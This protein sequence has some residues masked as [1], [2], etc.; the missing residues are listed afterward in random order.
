MADAWPAAKAVASVF[1]DASSLHRWLNFLVYA[2]F[3]PW[4]G[5]FLVL[6]QVFK[7]FRFHQILPPRVT[8]PELASDDI[9]K[10]MRIVANTY[11]VLGMND[12]NT[13]PSTHID[14]CSPVKE[15]NVADV[16]TLGQKTDENSCLM[17][18]ND[19]GKLALLE[20]RILPNYKQLRF[21]VGRSGIATIII[22]IQTTGYVL[23][24]V[25]RAILHLPVSPIETTSLAFNMVV[26][27][28]SIVHSVGAICQNPLVIYLNPIQQQDVL[29]K[30][31]AT[32]WSN[33]DDEICKTA[34]FGGMVVVAIL[35]M[36]LT[37]VVGWPVLTK[38]YLECSVWRKGWIKS[39]SDPNCQG[40]LAQYGLVFF[41][42]SLLAQL[43]WI[44][45]TVKFAK[46]YIS[47]WTAPEEVPTPF[48]I[49]PL[50]TLVGII[51]SIV[52]SIRN[53]TQCD[54]RT[55]SMIHIVPF[56]G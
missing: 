19:A 7:T 52:A 55:P 17:V 21:V 5:I 13:L 22:A 45:F 23:S 43:I 25:Y 50:L 40:S 11:I 46:Y 53:W 8:N 4:L 2:P 34:A 15:D 38:N 37:I 49:F 51:I 56:L 31:E 44:S 16:L 41:L 47:P 12:S 36:A 33:V 54:S 35:V 14:I 6:Q 10:T 24:I 30:C 28:H 27:V 42:I 32:R 29:D 9:L 18:L 1:G 26:I 20:C 39:W 3:G 48:A